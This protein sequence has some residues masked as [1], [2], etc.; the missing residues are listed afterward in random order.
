MIRALV[1]ILLVAAVAVVVLALAGDPGRASMIWLGWRADMTAAGAFLLVLVLSL[2]ATLAW[3][4]LF[5][6]LDAPRRAERSRAESRRRQANE[7]LSRGFLAA[8]GG[9]GP[10]AR[11]LAM[12]AAEIGADAPALAPTLSRVL[13]AQAAEAA[14]DAIAAQAAY[15]AMLG[16]PDMRLAGRRGLMQLALTQGDRATAL[17]YAQEAYAEA[18]TSRWAWRALLEFRLEAGDWTA[19]LDLVKGALD[20]KIAA[21]VMADRARAALLAASA[22]ALETALEIG[23]DP[24]L[25]AQAQDQATEAARLQ[26][27][28]A[29]GVVMAA[30][31]LAQGGKMGRAAQVLESAWKTAPHPALWLAYRDLRTNETPKERAARLRDLA[32]A[33]SG[34]RES[35]ILM[36]EQALIAGDVGAAQD[37]A[38]VLETWPVTARTAGLKARVAYAAHRPD[39][40]RLAL[41]QGQDAPHEPDWSDLDP[42]GRAFAYA[43]AD[44]ARLVSTFAETG[45]L[46]HPRLERRERSLSELPALPLAYADA[47]TFLTD[48]VLY[49]PDDRGWEDEAEAPQVPA[50]QP[51]RRSLAGGPRA[52]K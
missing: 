41:A 34:H 19:A 23:G 7:V 30:R 5:W 2:A 3:R 11:R 20:R 4:L 50:A 51:R 45:E 10:E 47:P 8:A 6:I 46:I 17:R 42:E 1:A 35:L 32:S 16:F 22:A 12:K 36:V 31:L 49:P 9:D 28:F 24:K 21:P 13:A 40:A 18:R 38:R 37:A 39:E 15:A 25:R 27:G 44:W 52:A 48:P 43:P 14:G 26:P 33:N 29:P